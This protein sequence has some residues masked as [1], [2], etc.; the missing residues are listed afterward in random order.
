MEPRRSTSGT[1][2]RTLDPSAVNVY[3]DA[4]PSVKD[5]IWGFVNEHRQA[6]RKLRR[7]NQ[8]L[9]GFKIKPEVYVRISERLLQAALRVLQ[10]NDNN[11]YRTIRDHYN[12]LW[13]AARYPE[14]FRIKDHDFRE[15][16]NIV[17]VL[18]EEEEERIQ[19]EQAEEEEIGPE[20]GNYATNEQ[21]TPNRQYGQEDEYD[22]DELND[23]YAPHNPE[24]RHAGPGPDDYVSD[25][26]LNPED[27]EE[28][29][30]EANVQSDNQWERNY[31]SIDDL[32]SDT[33]RVWGSL[34]TEGEILAYRMRGSMGYSVIVGY[35]CDDQ[36]IARVEPRARRP[37]AVSHIT[38]FGL[39]AWKV[40]GRKAYYPETYVQVYWKDQDWTWESRDGL[41]FVYGG[42]PYKVDVL[43]YR[44]AISQEG[45][46]QEALTGYRPEYPD[47]SSMAN[48]HW[49]N[50]NA[51]GGAYWL[52]PRAK[53]TKRAVKLEEEDAI[54]I[55]VKDEDDFLDEQQF[56]GDF[57]HGSL[58]DEPE[59]DTNQLRAEQ[60]AENGRRNP[61]SGCVTYHIRFQ[62][63]EGAG[64][65]IQRK[66]AMTLQPKDIDQVRVLWLE[67][68]VASIHP[69]H[70]KGAMAR[71]LRANGQMGIGA[72]PL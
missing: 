15:F 32:R 72:E 23:S 70:E 38:G 18:L 29:A 67:E 26:F 41:R 59:L 27:E 33:E 66:H 68:I 6:E 52:H 9:H 54:D 19:A 35:S 61:R 22:T 4:W 34:M 63:D 58:G 60:S 13:Q 46:Y 10:I 25:G 71:P 55:K 64:L 7:F 28:V 39:I 65:P 50:E 56:A 24:E 1:P 2:P 21:T 31:V 47:G 49:R 16:C 62:R 8:I 51:L 43:I 42:D 57:E 45:N 17:R 36:Q 37:L 14:E 3:R 20:V 48:K 12:R 69:E 40:D 30:E 5:L 44:Q 11:D 53:E